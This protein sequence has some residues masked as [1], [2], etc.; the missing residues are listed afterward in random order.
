MHELVRSVLSYARQD[1]GDVQFEP[2]ALGDAFS[3]PSGTSLD[4]VATAAVFGFLS[5]AGFE[6]AAAL[7]EETDE[8]GRNIPRAVFL[9]PLTVGIFYLVVILS[10]TLVFRAAR[11]RHHP[12][13][14]AGHASARRDEPDSPP[15]GDRFK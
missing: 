2:F 15:W 11:G 13:P 7:G 8:P 3:L 12:P 6:G 14:H 4:A 10:Q 5:F 1:V 9:A